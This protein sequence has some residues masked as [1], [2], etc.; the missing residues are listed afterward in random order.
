MQASYLTKVGD[1]EGRVDQAQGRQLYGRP[2]EVAHVSKQRLS[3]CRMHRQCKCHSVHTLRSQDAPVY[4][5][6]P[7][8]HSSMCVAHGSDSDTREHPHPYK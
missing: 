8:I 2:V 4:P 7:N 1:H 6:L 5:G 3:S